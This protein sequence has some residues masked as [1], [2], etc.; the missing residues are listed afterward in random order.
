MELHVE[1]DEW[2][3]GKTLRDCNLRD[4]GMLVLGIRRDDGSYVGTPRGDTEVY[5]GDTLIVYGR[6]EAMKELGQRQAGGAGDVAH[7]RAV[8]EQASHMAEQDRQER[9]QKRRRQ[10]ERVAEEA[11]C[12]AEEA[13]RGTE[14]GN[15]RA[16]K[17][18]R[19]RQNRRSD[20]EE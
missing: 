5:A 4:E 15:R 6:A 3:V 11:S 2:L 9:A 14:E 8:D 16:E 1:E 20:D 17:K 7:E 18:A 19:S 12:Q 13:A 10:A